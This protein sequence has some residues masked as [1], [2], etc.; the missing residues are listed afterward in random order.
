[1]RAKDTLVT[2]G[3]LLF[4]QLAGFVVGIYV[5]RS[6]GAADYGAITIARNFATILLTL[7]PIGLDLALLKYLP[8]A[9][10]GVRFVLNQ[11]GAFRGVVYL[12]NFG[13]AGLLVALSP[14]MEGRVYKFDNF[15]IIFAITIFAIP[16]S[17]DI[18]ILATYYKSFD[19]P[20]VFS[21]LTSYSQTFLRSLMNLAAII[22]G[23]GVVGVA[24]ST[25]LSVVLVVALIS[26]HLRA[27]QQKPLADTGGNLVETSKRRDWSQVR[28]VFKESYWMAMNLF[29]YGLTRS[30]DVLILGLFVSAHEV[31]SYGALGL[32]AYIVAV[33]P[34]ALSQTLGPNIAR[35]FAQGDLG[36]IN[37]V[38][39]RYIRQ[40]S[41]IAAFIFGGVAAFGERLDLL[42]GKS[43]HISPYLAL[44]LPLGHYVSALLAPT[45]YALSMTGRHKLELGVLVF[46]GVSLVGLLF[47]LAPPFG[48]VGAALAV[49]VA[50]VLTNVVRFVLVVRHIGSLPMRAMDL[51]PPVVA[52]AL[53]IGGRLVSNALGDQALLNV[54]LGCVAYAVAYASFVFF[55]FMS[56]S[57]RRAIVEFLGRVKHAS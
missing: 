39:S 51:V 56:A 6:L 20:G 17:T 9:K 32:V 38:L 54:I 37:N 36:G 18:N 24:A 2:A 44:L 8:T 46:G 12:I 25:T 53:A 30:V 47:V 55:L 3:G 33:Y 4:Q 48:A 26:L 16:F 42:L 49:L 14:I 35:L 5:A 23:F 43:F 11:F 50:F 31:G 10:G 41:L 15:A 45:G 21:L 27:W 34:I 28:G 29:V 57:E 1:M 19:R 40:A 7:T 22:L 13:V 52:L